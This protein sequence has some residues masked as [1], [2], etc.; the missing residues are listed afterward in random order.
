[1]QHAIYFP[2]LLLTLWFIGPSCRRC[3]AKNIVPCLVFCLCTLLVEFVLCNQMVLGGFTAVTSRKGLFVGTLAVIYTFVWLTIGFAGLF[4]AC[5]A[6]PICGKIIQYVIW[7]LLTIPVRLYFMVTNMLPSSQ[8]IFNLL[9]VKLEITYGTIFSMLTTEIIFKACLPNIIVLIIVLL[10][11]KFMPREEQPR[12]S[13]RVRVFLVGL[14]IFVLCFIP[15]KYAKNVNSSM[16]Y[17]VITLQQTYEDAKNYR[18]YLIQREEFTSEKLQQNPQNNIVLILDES[19]RGD[20]L[21][22]NTPETNTTPLLENYLRNYPANLF[23]YGLMI[24]SAT[25]TYP[26][27][28]MLLTGLQELPDDDKRASKSKRIQ[29]DINKRARRF[30]RFSIETF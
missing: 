23:N 15:P 9:S 3:I 4:M 29:D 19:I 27:R 18:I 24:S 12:R 17:S 30:A 1:M 5:R 10:L 8:D 13:Q 11:G 22:V 20:Y 28:F 21:S 2:V 16:G 7:C 14:L 25:Y 6:I 26:S